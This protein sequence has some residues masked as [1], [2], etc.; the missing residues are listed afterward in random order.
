L[1]LLIHGSLLLLS[2]ARIGP[3]LPAAGE[4]MLALPAAWLRGL[5]R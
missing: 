2:R 3:L 1:G 4:R 5:T